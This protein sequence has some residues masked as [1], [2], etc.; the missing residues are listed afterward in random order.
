MALATRAA[1]ALRG[2]PA[3]DEPAPERLPRAC[4]A[5]PV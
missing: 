3:P 1:F 2:A 4:A 5:T